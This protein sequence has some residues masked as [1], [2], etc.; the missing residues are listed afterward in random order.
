MSD[1]VGVSG[2][3]GWTWLDAVWIVII[4]ALLLRGFL[5]GLVQ[6]LLEV[7][8]LGL[9]VYAGVQLYRP[10]GAWLM[11]R[12]PGLPRQAALAAAFGGVAA[13][14]L[15]AG[16]VLTGM[17]VHLARTS[18]LSWA[19]SLGG[20]AVGALKGVAVVATLVVLIAGL[21]SGELRAE[22][23]D[24]VISRELRA[25]VPRLWAQAREA[26]PRLLPPLPA[27]GEPEAHEEPSTRTA[28]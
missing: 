15:L 19:D 6:E 9:A 5:R 2:Q 16:A 21:P 8:A 25:V 3:A 20:A 28:I 27:L 24:S 18:P 12:L 17:L 22:L 26:F 10:L 4:A 7:A 23:S 14:V 1:A 11:E 13:A